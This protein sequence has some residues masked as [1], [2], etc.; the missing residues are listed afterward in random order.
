MLGKLSQMTQAALENGAAVKTLD[1]YVAAS[2]GS[3][4]MFKPSVQ[5]KHML[6]SL[7]SSATL[8]DRVSA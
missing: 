1:A 4:A 7:R 5:Y 2:K 3:S 8:P 6:D